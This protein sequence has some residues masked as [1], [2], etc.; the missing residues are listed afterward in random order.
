MTM[1]TPVTTR[2][3]RTSVAVLAVAAGLLAGCGSQ[4]TTASPEAYCERIAPLARLGDLLVAEGTDLAALAAQISDVA[5]VAPSEVRPAVEEIAASVQTMADA[6]E[7]NGGEGPAAI[8]AA[9]AAIA[10]QSEQLSAA[11]TTVDDYT[12]QTCGIDLNEVAG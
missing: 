12:L 11:S 5:A 2:P 10:D 8:D 7:A 6:A 4:E 1:R 3:W 9:F